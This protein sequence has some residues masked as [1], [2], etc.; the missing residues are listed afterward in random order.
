[1]KIEKNKK[2]SMKLYIED[3]IV[4]KDIDN[5]YGIKI[6]EKI[7][8]IIL[9]DKNFPNE[10]VW[11]NDEAF[12]IFSEKEPD[13]YLL[14]KVIE[15]ILWLGEVKEELLNFYN[16]ENFRHKLPNA[17]EDWFDGLSIFDFSI[18]IDKNDDFNTEILLHD[19]IQNDFGFR[20]EIEN[21]HFK[22]I[23]YDPNL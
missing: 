22:Q 12:F 9:F 2:I 11:G 6:S 10:D 17:G 13:K 15:Y 5:G 8:K 14:E 18:C 23:K 7:K 16:K 1:M 20:L 19:H 4:S 21:K 3:F